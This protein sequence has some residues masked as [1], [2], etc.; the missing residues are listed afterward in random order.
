MISEMMTTP[1]INKVQTECRKAL[2]QKYV[3]L[4]FASFL[5]CWTTT[6]S[7]T[8]EDD[9][10]KGMEI[11][12]QGD[13]VG[14]MQPYRKAAAQGY[15]PAQV[16]LAA[17]FDR[18]EFDEEAELWYQKAVEQNNA[19]A[20]FGLGLMHITGEAP[21]PDMEKALSLIT[22]AAEQGLYKAIEMMVQAYRYGELGLSVN[23]EKAALWE[24]KLKKKTSSESTQ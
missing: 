12:Y 6:I 23:E 18:S 16:K 7:A 14:A 5:L 17:I 24:E 22:A 2:L 11:F 20:Q 9:T 10:K 3:C 19:E 8:P 13:I 21:E 4:F 1:Y 15:A